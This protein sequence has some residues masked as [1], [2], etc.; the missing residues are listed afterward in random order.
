MASR[1]TE[2]VYGISSLQ[3][4]LRAIGNRGQR[5]DPRKGLSEMEPIGQILINNQLGSETR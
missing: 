5:Q 2:A 4:L 3:V 1:S